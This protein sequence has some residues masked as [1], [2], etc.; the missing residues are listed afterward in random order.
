[1]KDFHALS[2]VG[3]VAGPSGS[4]I[5]DEQPRPARGARSDAGPVWQWLQHLLSPALLVLFAVGLGSTLADAGA[6]A[7][8]TDLERIG[9]ILATGIVSMALLATWL[10]F[11]RWREDHEVLSGRLAIAVPC[12][13]WASQSISSP[14][15]LA[16]PLT[17]QTPSALR[18]GVGVVGSW[19]VA[20]D[21]VRRDRPVTRS[22]AA[23]LL[24]SIV[25]ASSVAAGIRWGFGGRYELQS[26]VRRLAATVA[27]PALWGSVG[28][29]VLVSAR[30]P[31]RVLRRCLGTALLLL[32]V[33][34]LVAPPSLGV[35]DTKRAMAGG[36]AGL[37]SVFVLLGGLGYNLRQASEGQRCRLLA[38]EFD[39]A[40]GAS[41]LEADRLL[42]SSKAHDQKA[43]LLSIEAVIRLLENSEA[44][45]PGARQRLCDAATEELRRLRGNEPDSVES[46]L[47]EIVGPVVALA[48]LA[49][50]NVTMKIRPGL[51]I[52]ASPA[53][54]DVVRN[55]ISNAVRHGGNA[56]VIIEA[57]R[58]D[59]E[60][61]ELSVTD[62]GPGIRSS[63]RFDL[64]EAGRTSGGQESS[65]L[66]LHSAR[67]MLRDMGGDLQLDRSHV[68]GAR[69]T[70]RIPSAGAIRPT[71]HA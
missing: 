36:L 34:E 61:V 14:L 71:K 6:L 16:E 12:L 42:H 13:I 50:A 31:R 64:F 66:G 37:L 54:I 43:A 59:Y 48:N 51:V 68:G 63:R 58:L 10:A 25:A 69:F 56:D 67:S 3:R 15:L 24:L 47:R 11:T 22:F 23:G 35:A 7:T 55:L 40:Q 32:A 38:A 5:A 65:G 52:D 2:I 70:A 39:A 26:D 30:P 9:P 41:R 21:V 60:F 17:H 18:V 29:F 49:G 19:L 8:E 1:M 46:D 44:I 20:C 33:G 62:S 53:F 28:V 4:V 45:D 57:R 27:F